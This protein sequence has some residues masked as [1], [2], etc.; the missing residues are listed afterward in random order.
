M[1]MRAIAR[2]PKNLSKALYNIFV[3]RHYDNMMRRIK[4]QKWI[5][6]KNERAISETNKKIKS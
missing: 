4:G 2:K 6:L 1:S 3:M 5:D